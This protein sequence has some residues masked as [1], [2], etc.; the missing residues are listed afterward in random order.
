MLKALYYPH[1]DITSPVIIKNALLL[2]D[3][4]ETIVPQQAWTPKRLQRNKLFNE[5]VDIVVRPRVPSA[6]ERR[7]AHRNLVRLT[8]SG[9]V[10]SLM[11]R[12]PPSWQGRQYL[13][14]PSK[15]LHQTW[16][17]LQSGGMANWVVAA[18]DYGVPPAVGLLMMSILA[19]S[20][21]GTQIQ[22]VTDRVEAYSW[23]SEHYAGVL[24]RPHVTGLDASQVAPNYD[25]LVTLSLEA[26]DAR[27]IPLRKLVELR[28]RESRRGGT[29]YSAMRRRYLKHL[30]AHVKRI[31][32]EARS[33]T[34]VRELNRQFQEEMKQD[35]AD[36]K[37]ELGTASLKTLLSNKV[38]LSAVIA[39][40]CLISPAAGLTALSTKLVG[41]GVVPLLKAAVEY[42]GARRAAL[43][44]HT[45]SWLFL[46]GQ[47]RLTLH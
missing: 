10:T 47:G 28:K 19:D 26:L 24:G 22:K 33:A 40:G 18:R 5:A 20:C 39:A 41:I 14:Y 2:W 29:D 1:T 17:M 9:F 16:R 43:K 8:D 13:I 38:A 21:A 15:F 44:R 32:T 35:L 3:S 46:A 6:A 30:Q 45:S 42:R 34:D 11:L 12:S 4:I 23:L 27:E 37:N 25:R 36:L 31:G 7:D